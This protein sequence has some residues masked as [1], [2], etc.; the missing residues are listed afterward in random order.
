[1]QPSLAQ[2][3][4]PCSLTLPPDTSLKFAIDAISRTHTSCILVTEGP[5]LVGILTKRDIVRATATAMDFEKTPLSALM[6]REVVTCS[7]SDATNPFTI[8]TTLQQH[9][10]R[11]LPVTD[12][13]GQLSGIITPSSI[14]AAFKPEHWLS[15]QP[16]TPTLEA[17]QIRS[18]EILNNSPDL[19]CCFRAD[20]TLTFA[21]RAYC[22]F[23]NQSPE[24]ILGTSFLTLLP[25]PNRAAAIEK[26]ATLTQTKGSLTTEHQM[27]SAEGTWQWMQWTD[28]AICDDAGTILEFQAIGRDITDLKRIEETL[29]E[30]EARNRAILDA[31]P[32]MLL[33]VQRDGTCLDCILPKTD[34]AGQFL[35]VQHH[36]AEIL[37]PASVEAELA[38][39][40]RALSTRRLQMLEHHLVK[41]GRIV[42][43]EV[44]AVP[45]GADEV[46]L[47]VRDVTRQQQS[48]IQ[49]QRL[50]ENVPGVVYRYVLSRNGQD[51]ITYMSPR[52]RNL[53]GVEPEAMLR[54]IQTFWSLVHPE[55]LALMR[56]TIA[57][58][59]QTLQPCSVESRIL[60]PAGTLRWV[61]TF[62]HPELQP[63]GDV[64][65]DGLT[66]D[67]TDSKQANQALQISEAKLRS[68]LENTPGLISLIDRQGITQ[69]INQS[70]SSH[71]ESNLVGQHLTDYLYPDPE[72]PTQFQ[73]LLTTVFD[74]KET[75][76]FEAIGIGKTA[77][78]AHYEVCIAPI[79]NTEQVEA[80]IVIA[81]DISVRK[82]A[83]IA[84]QTSEARFRAIFEQAA[85]GITQ[86][87]LSG[88]FLQVNQR[89]CD[90]LGYTTAELADRTIRDLT[91][92]E[93]RA[94]EQN[95]IQQLI[96]GEIT[97]SSIEKRLI[98]KNGEARWVHV[99]SSLIR[100]ELYKRQYLLGIIEDIQER[101]QVE[102]NLKA[103]QAFLR[104]VIDAVSSAI[105]VKDAAGR[106]LI[107]NQAAAEVYGTTV[108]NLIGKTDLDFN[109]DVD[110]VGE[111][112]ATN[113]EVI[114]TQNKVV[115]IQAIKQFPNQESW[116][117][118][119]ISP[120][121]DTEGHPQGVIGVATNIT[122]LKQTEEALRQA[123]EVA[124]AANLAKSQFL[125]NMS[126]ELR[127]PLHSI[128]GFAQIL[129]QDRCLTQEQQEQLAIIL[130][131]GEHLLELIND[132]LEMSKIDAGRITF[133][134]NS[135]NLHQL[136]DNLQEILQA[137]AF[138]KGIELLFDCDP[139]V[140][141]YIQTD[142]NKL[143]QILLNLLGN[144]IKFTQIGKV[145]LRIRKQELATIPPGI[146]SSE[147]S[148]RL[149]ILPDSSNPLQILLT[150]PT[151]FI[152]CFTVEDTGPGIAAA[153]MNGLF[154]PFVQTET[155]RQSQ[156]GTGLGLA[157]S[158]RFV[159]LMGGT[160]S[161]SS[162]QGQ[163]A[164]FEVK[165]PACPTPA[166]HPPS[167]PTGKIIGLAPH[168]STRRIL[169]VEDQ[170]TNRKLVVRL[171][172][173]LGFDVQE[174]NDGEAAISLWERWSPHLI[175]MDMRMPRMDGYAATR[176][177][178]QQEQA[179]YDHL[180]SREADQFANSPLQP[181]A[182]IALTA[183]AF[184]EERLN[185][186][187]AGCNGYIPKPFKSEALLVAIAEH[188]QT[189]YIY[190]KAPPLANPALNLARYSQSPE[191]KQL[192]QK[193]LEAFPHSWKSQ[194][195]QAAAQLDDER[196]LELIHQVAPDY[197]QLIEQLTELVRE[198]RFDILMDLTLTI[199]D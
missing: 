6:T 58:A 191:L 140:P 147:I 97:S 107:A 32:D 121:V 176:M 167:H 108:E 157:I 65:W 92:S 71:A 69:F 62:T 152:L 47:M 199:E 198:F 7:E 59:I 112:W 52:C 8:F 166:D 43:E 30:S 110:Q 103:Q 150:D 80:A 31:I 74:Q 136:L 19:I 148:D 175:L 34:Q 182:I 158:R 56:H 111:F 99:T 133:N 96:T 169:V 184:E 124:E 20:G 61:R 11:H 195:Y 39:I 161:V 141:S 101:K 86:A 128:L 28:F 183:S 117:Q 139:H 125:A 105:F 156:E 190:A 88:T 63:N 153:E 177:I 109:S 9:G 186:F 134:P 38:L 12:A 29:R 57:T 73:T 50:T 15:Y 53:F 154:N 78:S 24:E 84:L 44:R 35:A 23:L 149:Q 72:Q 144:A 68:I 119:A 185:I 89:F 93:D 160:I 79:Q 54:D 82:Q 60:T 174:A 115:V 104:K 51:R 135:F 196:C 142:E 127:T 1:M 75:I 81:A 193:D 106:F 165:L 36:I 2:V 181:V 155:G 132:V 49:F 172:T 114:E 14:Q 151:A 45:C 48:E 120:F 94:L 66:I 118:L 130:R 77:S 70:L 170:L 180:Q 83:E 55:D 197:L 116:Y 37:P 90:L 17:N 129:H 113:R 40:D 33:R 87:T 27:V 137:K 178:R 143:R 41:N 21:N 100:D 123:K 67:V 138:A 5:K 189:E 168:Q 18:R 192:T 16:S 173:K 13:E 3:V 91:H 187:A 122:G 126:H 85:V 76:E 146:V 188:L 10:I 131:S 164:T 98:C 25:E 46:L 102:S 179:R 26:I 42:Y 159:E 162:T 95:A 145:I 64:V 4:Q 171:L 163:G 22:R 194:L